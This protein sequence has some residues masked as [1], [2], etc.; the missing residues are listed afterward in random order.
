MSDGFETL[1]YA[2]AIARNGTVLGRTATTDVVLPSAWSTIDD[3]VDY[4]G[5][6]VSHGHESFGSA[7]WK[8]ELKT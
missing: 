6:E 2:E 3:W 1:V 5:M 4:R 7:R 8:N